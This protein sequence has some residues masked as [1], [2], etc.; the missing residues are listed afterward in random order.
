MLDW[1][2]G[3]HGVR[4][5]REWAH[6]ALAVR[7][8]ERAIDIGAGTGSETHRLAEATGEAI[9]VEPNPGLRSVAVQRSRSARFIDGDTL[10]LPFDDGS[11]DVVWC[12]RVFQHLADSSKVAREVARV[13]RP[14]G[15]AAVL[16]T[17]SG[18]TI[19]YPGDRV[20]GEAVACSTLDAAVD[21]YAGRKISGHLAQAGLEIED[22]GSQAL[23]QDGTSFNWSF[24][25][26]LAD[27][28]VR[29]E[30]ITAEQRDAFLDD[31]HVGAEQYALHMSV[32]MF[33]VLARSAHRRQLV[34]AQLRRERC[35]PLLHRVV[36]PG[37]HCVDHRCGTIGCGL[38]E[39]V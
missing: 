31:L 20:V 22:V 21:P 33:A 37:W 36:F 27:T 4:R 10:S 23:H 3:N 14:G 13:L 35:S 12:E 6:R 2:A 1:H 26:M 32:T 38:F 30:R 15:R 9:G 11:V 16:D 5:L 17:D 28:A 34:L 39:G 25:R 24:V 29:A 19:L 8:G 18:T 7:P